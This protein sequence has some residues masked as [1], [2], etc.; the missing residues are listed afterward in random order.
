MQTLLRARKLPEPIAR[1]ES[2]EPAAVAAVTPQAAVDVEPICARCGETVSEKVRAYCE[3]HRERFGGLAYCY[4][5]QRSFR[6][7]AAAH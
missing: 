2:P 5:H 1:V 7:R 3:A 6:R 4:R